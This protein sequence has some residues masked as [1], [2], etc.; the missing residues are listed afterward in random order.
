[1]RL[2]FTE[3]QQDGLHFVE[4]QH[5]LF[6]RDL[7]SLILRAITISSD[8]L[9]HLPTL[10]LVNMCRVSPTIQHVHVRL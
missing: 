8:K 1:M 6:S 3:P 9:F 10:Q 7:N 4:L 2:L 5:V